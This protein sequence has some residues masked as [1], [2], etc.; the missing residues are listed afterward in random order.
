M[1]I[2]GEKK[3]ATKESA[4][5]NARKKM[6]LVLV[7]GLML[8]IVD[9]AMTF[10]A[11]G[12]SVEKAGHDF[13]ITRPSAGEEA[14]HLSLKARVSGSNG[15]VEEKMNVTVE[16]YS[17]E[18]Q[19]ELAE[20]PGEEKA[21]TEEE[22]EEEIRKSLRDTVSGLNNDTE[23]MKV[24]LPGSLETGERIVWEAGRERNSDIWSTLAL[25][26]VII[27][28]IYKN[29][30]AV[31]ERQRKENRQSVMRQLP[32]FV[33]RLVLL[34]NAGL[35][36]SNAFERS[37]EESFADRD[38]DY[39]YGKLRE[40]YITCKNANGSMHLEFRRMAKESG[41]RELMRVSNIISDNI[42]KGVELTGKL[43]AESE[44]LWLERKK[45]CEERGR[46]AETK[47]TLPLMIFLMVLMIITVAPALLEL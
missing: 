2:K 40:I 8:V 30:F 38:E 18:S 47:L 37:V 14:G 35:V 1:K 6:K 10:S 32:E 44:M 9:L 41:I 31:L 46:L 27:F 11:P 23:K 39:F 43:Q 20:N 7:A 5:R 16:P 26:G 24:K 12:I 21:L 33:N 29:R 4:D 17:N 42:K 19:R 15:T 45:S 34:L 28:I 36:L 25:T 13:Y 22:R 3:I